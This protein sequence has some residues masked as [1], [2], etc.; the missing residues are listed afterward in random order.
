MKKGNVNTQ[1]PQS[2]FEVWLEISFR[3]NATDFDKLVFYYTCGNQ[4]M[5]TAIIIVI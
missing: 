2:Q 4:T 1:I 3:R 5:G